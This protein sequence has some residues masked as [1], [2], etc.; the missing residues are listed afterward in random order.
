MEDIKIDDNVKVIRIGLFESFC[1]RICEIDNDSLFRY[2]IE[3]K[4]TEGKPFYSWFKMGE[5]EKIG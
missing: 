1:G 3:F 4:S 5:I 2:K